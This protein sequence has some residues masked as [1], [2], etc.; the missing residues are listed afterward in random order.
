M[1]SASCSLLSLLQDPVGGGGEGGVSSWQTAHWCV[2]SPEVSKPTKKTANQPCDLLSPIPF[3]ENCSF[4][5]G[6]TKTSLPGRLWR[7][8]RGFQKCSRR[9]CSVGD[10]QRAQGAGRGDRRCWPESTDFTGTQHAARRL[11][12]VTQWCHLNIVH[13]VTMHMTRFTL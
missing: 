13:V 6:H 7:T 4:G 12:C 1:N 2:P 11:R 10:G 3:M 5:D 9:R 8:P